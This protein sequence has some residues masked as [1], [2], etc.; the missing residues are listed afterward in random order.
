MMKP[1]SPSPVSGLRVLKM[2]RGRG[3]LHEQRGFRNS[4]TWKSNSS[5]HNAT[6][7][8]VPFLSIVFSTQ[9]AREEK[10][11][12]EEKEMRCTVPKPP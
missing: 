12:E 2:N 10:G 6:I 1:Y 4:F 5:S 9:G 3:I 7:S 11:E 8:L